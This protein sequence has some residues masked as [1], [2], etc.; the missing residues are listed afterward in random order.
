LHDPAGGVVR[1]E[2]SFGLSTQL[3]LLRL[4]TPLRYTY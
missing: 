1:R 2:K 4:T 3:N